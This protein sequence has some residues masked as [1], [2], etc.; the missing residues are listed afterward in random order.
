M[1][2]LLPALAFFFFIPRDPP[3]SP[4][5][6]L[7]IR[8]QVLLALSFFHFPRTWPFLLIEP[9]NLNSWPPLHE[10]Q[11][12]I[13]FLRNCIY[14][15]FVYNSRASLS[16]CCIVTSLFSV[17][18]N[19]ETWNNRERRG[20]ELLQLKPEGMNELGFNYRTADYKTDYPWLKL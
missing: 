18:F 4:L 14:N 11:T 20:C 1:P 5:S 9:V 3:P 10:I 12:V 16:R 15:L 2:A 13:S 7:A 19:M 8:A 6:F 17:E